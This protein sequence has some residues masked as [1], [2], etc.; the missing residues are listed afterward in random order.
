M[1]ICICSHHA[2]DHFQEED[3]SDDEL[4]LVYG[5]CLI[6]GCNCEMFEEPEWDEELS[7]A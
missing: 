2:D 1:N 5:E 7:D 4:K 6:D 3:W